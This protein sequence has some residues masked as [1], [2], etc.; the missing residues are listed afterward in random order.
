MG[1]YQY[2]SHFMIFPLEYTPFP[3]ILTSLFIVF[4]SSTSKLRTIHPIFTHGYI[5]AT[6]TTYLNIQDSTL[7]NGSC[8]CATAI[9]GLP[10]CPIQRGAGW[11]EEIIPIETFP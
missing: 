3:R 1:Y 4:Y 2:P 9:E 6:S 11:R 8:I 7:Y 10:E 5:A